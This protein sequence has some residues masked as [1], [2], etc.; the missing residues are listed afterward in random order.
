M[1]LVQ[2]LKLKKMSQSQLA[3]L[4]GTSVSTINRHITHGRVLDP[5]IV[6]RIFFITMGAVRP[7]DFYDLETCPPELESYWLGH[8][9][10]NAAPEAS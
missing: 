8:N 9:S 5:K 10:I 3:R 4:A 6:V 7:D 2:W 1:K